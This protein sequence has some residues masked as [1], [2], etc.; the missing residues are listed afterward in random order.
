M[1]EILVNIEEIRDDNPV[2]QT[3]LALASRHGAY[4]TGLNIVEVFPTTMVMPDVMA[5][6]ATQEREARQC[7]AWWAKQCCGHGVQGGWE[8][9]RAV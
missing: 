7:D 1:L 6:L 3:G 9:I 5:G 2:V 8:V 4:A